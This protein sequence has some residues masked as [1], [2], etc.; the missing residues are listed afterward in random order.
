MTHAFFF[1][2]GSL[3]N[4]ATHDFYHA[5]PAR[6]Y[7]WERMWVQTKYA[8]QKYL[9]VRK[10]LAKKSIF[11]LVAA[12]PEG[13]WESLDI[14][15]TGYIRLPA[16]NVE[17]PFGAKAAIQI[18]SIPDRAQISCQQ[19]RGGI[20]LSYLDVVTQGF[21]TEF[22]E[23]GVAHFFDTTLHWGKIIN[24][25]DNPRYPRCQSLTKAEKMLVDAHIARLALDI[26]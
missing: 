12:V 21:S 8:P 22:G 24:D 15:E 2:Y 26:E 14:R 4:R 6:I 10:T 25:R 11:G 5:A 3:V 17:H 16:H 23:K 1:G 20:L 7:G 19:A 13:G 18:Y 9:S